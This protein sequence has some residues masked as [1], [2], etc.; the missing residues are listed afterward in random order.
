M[1][2][3]SWGWDRFSSLPVEVIS[4][5]GD[6]LTLMLEPHVEILAERLSALPS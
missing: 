3:S 6:H 5:P 4:L 1:E 2:E